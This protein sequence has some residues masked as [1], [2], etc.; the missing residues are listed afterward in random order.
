[1]WLFKISK[2]KKAADLVVM[3]SHKSNGLARFLFGSHT[4][5]VLDNINCPVLLVPESLKYKGISSMAYATDLTFNDLKVINYLIS[6]A[7]PFN[8]EVFVSHI[9]PNDL[10]GLD[11]DKAILHVVNELLVKDYPMVFYSNVKR[12]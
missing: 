12:R 4:H 11:P 3:G 8:A 7:K 10:P 2:R 5:N 9:S 6:I 1:M